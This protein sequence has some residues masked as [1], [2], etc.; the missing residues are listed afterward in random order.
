ME[1]KQK[2]P[3]ATGFSGKILIASLLKNGV[4]LRVS[5]SGYRLLKERLGI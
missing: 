5:L 3:T 4:K 2:F 1:V